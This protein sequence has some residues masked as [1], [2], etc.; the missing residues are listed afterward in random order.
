MQKDI[1]QHKSS[2]VKVSSFLQGLSA[3]RKILLKVANQAEV[4]EFPGNSIQLKFTVLQ[5]G[6]HLDIERPI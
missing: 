2:V 3:R 4:V 6:G 1:N 5:M